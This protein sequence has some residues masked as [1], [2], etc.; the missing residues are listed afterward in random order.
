[1]GFENKTVDWDAYKE[2]GL[3]ILVEKGTL[4]RNIVKKEDL[5]PTKNHNYRPKV[6]KRDLYPT[7]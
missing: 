1:M 7:R 6:N 4:K 5:Y 3:I 2:S